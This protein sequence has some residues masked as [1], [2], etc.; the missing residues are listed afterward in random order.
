[1]SA[2]PELGGKCR[3]CEAI[4]ASWRT[5]VRTF[6]SCTLC[7]DSSLFPVLFHN[8]IPDRFFRPFKNDGQVLIPFYKKLFFG[9]AHTCPFRRLRRHLSQGKASHSLLQR[10]FAPRKAVRLLPVIR[11]RLF[12][13]EIFPYFSILLIQKYDSFLP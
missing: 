8:D 9:S 7:L 11:G 10:R 4:G 12:L 2:S 1:M 6:K 3:A 5:Q 13:C